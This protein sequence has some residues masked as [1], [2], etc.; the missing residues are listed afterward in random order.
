MKLAKELSDTD[1]PVLLGAT[2]WALARDAAV[3]A[4]DYLFVDEAGQSRREPR[5]DGVLCF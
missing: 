2:A 1:L 3:G 5:G 4:F